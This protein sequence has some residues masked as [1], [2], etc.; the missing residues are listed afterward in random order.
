LILLADICLTK[1]SGEGLNRICCQI[2]TLGQRH[3]NFSSQ[4][5][6]SHHEATD[7]LYRSLMFEEHYNSYLHYCAVA[8]TQDIQHGSCC[9]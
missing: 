7:L 9:I 3:A 1:P 6:L 8:H 5:P 4:H 2:Q